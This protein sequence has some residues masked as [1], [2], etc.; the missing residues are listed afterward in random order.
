ME[1]YEP[2]STPTDTEYIKNIPI[3]KVRSPSTNLDPVKE[4]TES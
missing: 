4:N 2:Q 3:V 1:E